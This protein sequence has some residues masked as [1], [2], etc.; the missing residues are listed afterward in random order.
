M[1]KRRLVKSDDGS[2]GIFDPT[3][4]SVIELPSGA[5][6]V[7]ADDGSYGIFNNGKVEELDSFS[8]PSVTPTI[9][10]KSPNQ[11]IAPS[12][13]FGTTSSTVSDS[14]KKVDK[15]FFESL[16]DSAYNL[17]QSVSSS[18][19]SGILSAPAAISNLV[20]G[21]GDA[22]LGEGGSS[23]FASNPYAGLT[24]T[25]FQKAE[26][27]FKP[28][29]ERKAPEENVMTPVFELAQK[30]QE[31]GDLI[32]R[33]AK[34]S[35]GIS[36]KDLDKGFV[37]LVTEGKV[38]DAFKVAGLGALQSLPTSMALAATGPAA[39]FAGSTAIGAGA[40][41]G[42]AYAKDKDVSSVDMLKSLG[43]GVFEGLSESIF[44]TDLNALRNIAKG[45]VT[46]APETA[47]KSLIK[48]QGKDAVKQEI[49]RGYGG[50]L[51][52][53]LKGAGEEG[54][55]E[56]VSTIGSFLVDRVDDGKWNEKNFQ[57]LAKDSV[58]AF[59]IGALSGGGVSG[60]SALAS[61]QDLTDEQKKKVEMFSEVANNQD[62]SEDVRN[63]AKQKAKEIIKYNADLSSSNYEEI[64]DL[65]LE[66][67]TQVFEL[68][69][70][71]KS[72][73]EA[74]ADIKDIDT[75]A[76]IDKKIASLNDEVNNIIGA[77]QQSKLEAQANELA[78]LDAQDKDA[79]DSFINESGIQPIEIDK[80]TDDDIIANATALQELQTKIDDSEQL[81]DTQKQS[82]KL[83]VDQRIQKLSEAKPELVN[84]A[85]GEESL[86]ASNER[87]SQAQ[88][89]A[90]ALAN[91]VATVTNKNN[92]TQQYSVGTNE[93]GEVVLK[94]KMRF[95]SVAQGAAIPDAISI[96]QEDLGVQKIS[97]DKDGKVESFTFKDEKTGTEFTI[98][99]TPQLE[100]KFNPT[101]YSVS[102]DIETNQVS[103]LLNKI[104]P[105][106]KRVIS[107]YTKALKATM[108]NM[109]VVL[110]DNAENMINSLVDQ[111]YSREYAIS[112]ATN[113]NGVYAKAGNTIHLNVNSMNESTFG[114]EIF[115]SVFSDM[116]KNN[117]QEFSE[118][119]R[120]VTKL[121]KS[122][123][124]QE[125]LGKEA[126]DSLNEFAAQYEDGD[127][128]A[129]EF[130]AELA[131]VFAA[132]PTLKFNKPLMQDLAKI[133][134]DF[135]SK[136][137]KKLNSD[138][139]QALADT[140]F[141]EQ[142]KTE[143]IASFIES[144]GKSLREGTKI[145]GANIF[146]TTKTQDNAVQEQTA[147]QVPVQPESAISR[148]VAQGEPQSE[149]QVTTQEGQQQEEITPTT[150]GETN[151][152]PTATA[153]GELV[154][155][156]IREVAP[157]SK[158]KFISQA[159][160]ITPTD[161]EDAAIL[162]FLN[163]GQ[164]TPEAFKEEATGQ[165]SS[166]ELSDRKGIVL[167]PKDKRAGKEGLS[168]ENIGE[169]VME[170]PFGESLA[171]KGIDETM[172]RSAAIDVALSYSNRTQMA[173]RLLDKYKI[174][175]Q[176]KD[177]SVSNEQAVIN[178]AYDQ[179]AADELGISLEEF[180]SNY[181]DYITDEQIDQEAELIDE[182]Q[183]I[184]A[185]ME[186]TFD[187]IYSKD[188]LTQDQ[189][190]K[191]DSFFSFEDEG[192]IKPQKKVV[193]PDL[194]KASREAK[195]PKNKIK[196]SEIKAWLKKQ[197][198]K[199]YKVT[200][201][202]AT[203]AIDTL[204]DANMLYSLYLQYTKAGASLFGNLKY[205]KLYNEIYQ[206][207]SSEERKVLDNIIFFRRVIAVDS[208]FDNRKEPRPKH[209]KRG[210]IVNG[211][212][213][214]LLEAT[215]K[216]SALDALDYYK[217]ILG[218]E[219][220]NKLINH[221][222]MYFKA[223]R[224]IL[225]DKL[226]EGLID[227]NTYKLYEDYEYSPRKFLKFLMD[228]NNVSYNQFMQSGAPISKE[229]LKKI[230]EGSEEEINMDSANLLHAAMIASQVR[231]SN[232]QALRALYQ[233][234]LGKKLSFVKEANYKRDASGNIRRDKNGNPLFSS[235]AD[236][237][238]EMVGYKENGVYTPFQLKKDFLD[239]YFGNEKWDTS[240]WLYQAIKKSTLSNVMRTFATGINLGFVVSNITND[241]SFQVQMTDLYKGAPFGT[242]GQYATYAKGVA[243]LMPSLLKY[244]TEI[245]K[246]S[247]KIEDLL[248]EYAK[249]G[250][251]MMTLTN[252]Y[253]PNE[254]GTFGKEVRKY[255]GALGNSSEMASKL[256]A[257][258]F[259]RDQLVKEWKAANPG[260][261]MTEKQ[262]NNIRTEAAYRARSAMD[263]A[264]GGLA[265][266][267]LNGLI[268]YLNVLTQSIRISGE[269]INK[270]KWEFSK[271]IA[272]AGIAVMAI[273]AYNMS[274]AGDDYD[275][276]DVQ[277]DLMNKIV[278]FNPNKNEDGTRGY[279]VANIPSILKGM[280]NIFQ[281]IAEGM[282]MRYAS[283]DEVKLAKWKEH[284]YD[285]L[286]GLLDIDLTTN[287]PPFWKSVYEY[288]TN[289]NLWQ[290]RKI[291]DD[292]EKSLPGYEGLY[293]PRVPNTFKEFGKLTGLSPARLHKAFGNVFTESNNLVGFA[294]G[295]SDNV[296]NSVTNIP[297]AERSKYIKDGF[298]E[299]VSYGFVDKLEGRVYKKSD[300]TIE[301]QK[302]DKVA[303]LISQQEYTKIN[304][305]KAN[306]K[307]LVKEKATVP[308]INKYLESID[309]EYRKAAN[310]YLETATKRSLL[311]YPKMLDDYSD[312]AFASNTVAKA[313][314][315]YLKFPFLN[316]PGNQ[317]LKNDLHLMGIDSKDVM[318]KYNEYVKKGGIPKNDKVSPSVD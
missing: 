58:D 33:S 55:E 239:E 23:Q 245:G 97:K 135:L 51:K 46:E 99:S 101:S 132:N 134:Y 24:N 286:L 246:P 81:T 233:E 188:N 297:K 187:D 234:S 249:A 5:K 125:S 48:E 57:K 314:I 211:V 106:V 61:K 276:D 186:D 118:M 146:Q 221:A 4:N 215:N 35:A 31:G 87:I 9:E 269:Y 22:I 223:F 275:N 173:E 171:A 10:K 264:R 197:G 266:K 235:E 32:Q 160:E 69:S 155:T 292:F 42:E 179:N 47:I 123:A 12:V 40:G 145:E 204:E 38:A 259:K 59:V 236:R 288:K 98:P 172:I 296:I 73:E 260:Q 152:Q 107:Q 129:E 162:F 220:Y 228:K 244:E 161:A 170:G 231:I 304:E 70:R 219:V 180:R 261:T 16:F 303:D 167:Q 298:A 7:K 193:Y 313:K 270:N 317:D 17:E 62:L 308:K 290:N 242:A 301:Y 130:M 100:A 78:A 268:P 44:Q 74:K 140:L 149:A 27:S 21:I 64:A 265:T 72:A 26:E 75:Q 185:E 83:I 163:G 175:D 263:Y 6:A 289:K 273:T 227:Q 148:E 91:N 189:Q 93:N 79:V 309:V 95:S 115:H 192:E 54:V 112:Q 144:F 111:G 307:L 114:H 196:I 138:S 240:G 225:K 133:V 209:P 202:D 299:G 121:M 256:T 210:K 143:Q 284:A 15:G 166:K 287:I 305:V 181:R 214:N 142:V 206:P 198:K 218:D 272:Q 194:M 306:M 120:R 139:I 117:P 159:R 200:F 52:N 312:I 60:I 116:A 262:M 11:T 251:L 96:K 89:V 237:G 311:K 105:A 183:G 169:K 108:P 199:F 66:Q 318:E 258:T 281:N 49:V 164:I 190:D 278:I 104:T 282:Y 113:A 3:T 153:Q 158:S 84:Q 177:T 293:D 88:P 50:V 86:A 274:V 18:L 295:L 56:I 109:K 30:M 184:L 271:K 279:W 8:M 222:D 203:N 2:Y 247:K 41:I 82:A 191:L 216:E 241:A 205:T 25:S 90:S 76:D 178:Q 213:S 34:K 150:N 315:L 156:N 122:K 255:L 127:V 103:P 212:L 67:R 302:T 208:N 283:N 154:Q 207:L 43:Y 217:S 1:S 131:G 280:L 229:E 182:A 94:P 248:Y 20:A 224:Q 226:E 294:Y 232:N 124:T 238:F 136:I 310:S 316:N 14:K 77:N 80:A 201:E 141:S 39:V 65:P 29:L 291:T 254:T 63:I 128:A 68:L 19:K 252:D 147:G 36:D 230:Q 119:R 37:D 250:G 13:S 253:D 110:H 174:G 285:K 28:K 45:I 300:P 137:A 195:D 92:Q 85:I 243:S 267:Y 168:F 157:L 151:Q 165:K 257:Y 71:V 277:Q 53:A 102:E 176:I 126:L